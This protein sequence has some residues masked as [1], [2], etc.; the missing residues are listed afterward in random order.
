[1]Q[2]HVLPPLCSMHKGLSINFGCICLSKK[3]LFTHLP[4]KIDVFEEEAYI[5]LTHPLHMSSEVFARYIESYRNC[6]SSRFYSHYPP[7]VSKTIQL[8]TSPCLGTCIVTH[9]VWLDRNRKQHEAGALTLQYR[10][11]CTAQSIDSVQCTQGI[12]F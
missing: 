11:L 8:K 10:I 2:L 3:H 6:F 7:L 9:T 5:M 4:V 12:C 1:M